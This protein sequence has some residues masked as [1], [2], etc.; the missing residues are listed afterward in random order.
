MTDLVLKEVEVQRLRVQP[1]EWLLI[2]IDIPMTMDMRE[3]TRSIFADA[4]VKAGSIVPPMLFVDHKVDVLS[5]SKEQAVNAS[6]L[7]N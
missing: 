4:F 7:Q 2:R 6:V 1:G 3:R 5:V